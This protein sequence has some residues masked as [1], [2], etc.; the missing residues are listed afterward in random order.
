M[1]ATNRRL[2]PR[3]PLRAEEI[4]GLRSAVADPDVGLQILTDAEA[5][6]TAGRVL[7]TGDRLRFFSDR[8]HREMM[9]EIR[10]TP[11]EARRTGDGIDIATLEMRDVDE[12]GLRLLSSWPVVRFLRSLG[13][14]G[15]LEDLSRRA[16]EAASAVALLTGAGTA[17]VDYFNGG[18]A[19]E[20]MWLAATAMGLAVQPMSSLP[21]LFA[22][23]ERGAGFEATERAALEGLRAR[24]ARLFRVGPRVGELLLFRVSRAEPPTARSLR[25]PVEMVLD[26]A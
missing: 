20:R 24:Y 18:R 22:R 9:K 2:G 5:L 23:L 19:M 14:G 26:F 3:V 1:R 13:M 10:W 4:A 12:A 16:V 7:G 15:A 8:L 21:Y 17:P 11:E 25:R 6:D